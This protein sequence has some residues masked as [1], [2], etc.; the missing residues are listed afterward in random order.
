M[1]N[2]QVVVSLV[3]ENRK[4]ND[5][6]GK[7]TREVAKLEKQ[8]DRAKKS[9]KG[10]FD[11]VKH[12][13]LGS[14]GPLAGVG[15]AFG[16]LSAASGF[17]KDSV[18]DT[19]ALAV[20][21]K[22]MSRETGM[23][24]KSSSEWVSLA[25]ERG[26]DSNKLTLS[27]ASLSKQIHS[28]AGGSKSAAKAF[29][30]VG[31]SGRTIAS[32][33]MDKAL[34]NI[35]D[36]F[37]EM[38]D[39]PEKTALALQLFGRQG[40]QLLPIL[41]QGSAGVGKLKEEMDKAGLSMGGKQVAA[42]MKLKAAQRDLNTQVEGLKVRL[43][44]ALIPALSKAAGGLTEFV[45]QAVEGK[46][47]GGIFKD[48]VVGIAK[49]IK[50]LVKDIGPVV[51]GIAS[52]ANKHPEVLKF[53]LAFAAV[54]AVGLKVAK[55]IAVI[56][57]ALEV[58]EVILAPLE[59]ELLPFIA[60]ILIVAGL[61]Y[62]IYRNWKPISKFFISQWN[63]IKTVTVAVFNFLKGFFVGAF[64]VIKNLFSSAASFLVSAARRGFLGPI[65]FIISRWKTVIGFFK[66]LPGQIVS[67]ILSLPGK[68]GSLI[69]RFASVGASIGK[70]FVNGIGNAIKGAGSFL[71]DVGRGIADWINDHT[72]FGNKISL[73]PL[74]VTLPKLAQG[75]IVSG[76]TMA[77]I[78]EAGPEAV[79]PLSR[80]KRA[81]GAELYRE[82]GE[83]LGITGGASNNFVI[84]NYGGEMDETVLAAR[85]AW[86]LKTRAGLA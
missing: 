76:P 65:P 53:A 28:A 48:A 14:I 18:K 60:A 67:F 34:T 47:A 85:M 80:S 84:N 78:G 37:K 23:D 19:E 39:G 57:T 58:F 31:V 29:A 54:A 45:K 33:N 30:E 2:K 5:A 52:F 64:N 74:S 27:F 75:A 38:K 11:G 42:A 20:A 79:I 17:I 40:R 16:S 6:L 46:G 81:R 83:R 1:A 73:G 3:A 55:A 4:L 86:Q 72:P 77:L 15:A 63:I 12:S 25:K 9:G 24:L 8:L 36:K 22:K 41:N 32:G 59:I 10:S 13:A 66:A 71:H 49:A 44:N 35:S 56:S 62:L 70:S 21:T 68:L 82:A 50:D 69:S 51:K 61:A 26:V 43:G 7:S